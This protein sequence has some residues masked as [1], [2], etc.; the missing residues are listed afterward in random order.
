MWGESKLTKM[1]CSNSLALHFINKDYVTAEI[2][3]TTVHACH[4]VLAWSRVTVCRYV[5]PT[6]KEV[7][8]AAV[9]R[10]CPLGQP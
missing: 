1:A 9:S 8:I 6:Y 7:G 3:Y 10:L 4:N 5:N 2:I